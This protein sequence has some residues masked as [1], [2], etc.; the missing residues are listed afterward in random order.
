M[1]VNEFA[2]T[3]RLKTGTDS[4]G[5]T[6]IPGKPRKTRHVED[7]CHVFEFEEGSFGL[8]YV[9]PLPYPASVGK[10]HNAQ[11]RLLAAGFTQRQDGD[12][13]GIFSFDP[14]DAEQAKLAI[15]TCG[16]KR[17]RNYTPEQIEA[18][19]AMAANLNRQRQQAPKTG[20]K[21]RVEREDEEKPAKS[22]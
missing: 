2:E 9:Q 8:S 7:R 20:K 14:E 6:I 16:I 4:C 21:T 11:K 13:E 10:Y 17:E 22:A 3:Y 15:I 5:E 19:R 12:H 1:T 18:K